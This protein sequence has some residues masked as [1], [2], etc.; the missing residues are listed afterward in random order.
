MEVLFIR[1]GLAGERDALLWPDDRDRPL[2]PKGERRFR[3]V[4]RQL[5]LLF[6]RAD[7]V[8]SSPLTRAWQ[9]AEILSRVTRWPRPQELAALV[10]DSRPETLLGFLRERKEIGRVVLV[11]HEP[12]LSR[13]LACCI[14]RSAEGTALGMRKG[15]VAQVRFPAEIEAGNGELRALLPPRVL[16]RARR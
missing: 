10:P 11:G 5:R 4:A 14:S 13:A 9:T 3:R 15:G 1:H 8:W 7:V 12:A 2:T 6:P 16:L